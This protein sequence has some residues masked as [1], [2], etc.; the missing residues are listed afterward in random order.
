MPYEDKFRTLLDNVFSGPRPLFSLSEKIWNPPADVY[1]VEDAI[2]I[3]MEVA[4]IKEEE[5]QIS[6]DSNLLV[7]RGYRRETHRAP[8]Q[9][10]HLMEINYGPFERVFR[11]PGGID[12][13]KV[14][15]TYASGFLNV[16]LPKRVPAPARVKVDVK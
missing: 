14:E 13:D 2:L 3:V 6:L 15:A 4:G 7:I 10:Y 5:L 9:S 1:E 12:G 8:K 11:L 16:R